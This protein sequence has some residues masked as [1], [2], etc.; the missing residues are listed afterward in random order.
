MSNLQE[1]FR[2]S[3][4]RE[5]ASIPDESELHYVFSRRFERKMRRMIR[6]QV[7]G[8]WRLVN[9]AAKRAAVAA[10]II[11]LLLTS[12][13]AIKPIRERVIKF[14]VEV[15]EEYFEIH[16][17]NEDKNDIVPTPTPMDKYTLTKLPEGYTLSKHVMLDSILW[18]EWENGHENKIIL[19]QEPGTHE[20]T[21]DN[22]NEQYDIINYGNLQIFVHKNVDS[23]T[24]IWVHNVYIFTLTIY[25]DLP[26]EQAFNLI[27]SMQIE[28]F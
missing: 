20:L 2:E 8:Y 13:M 17:G 14:F 16:F 21:L 7:H 23:L 5:F 3:V 25:D 28:N 15:Y 26:L 9:T 11:L 19:Q 27:D 4:A 22:I 6:A 12:A 10:A 24:L 1:A 18:S